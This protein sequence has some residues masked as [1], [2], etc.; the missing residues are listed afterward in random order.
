MSSFHLTLTFAL[1][2]LIGFTMI[3]YGLLSKPREDRASIEGDEVLGFSETSAESA[4]LLDDMG[5]EGLKHKEKEPFDP[6]K[7]KPEAIESK[8]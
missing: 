6:E 3:V 4:K 2:S 8:K 7:H 1:M 5:Y